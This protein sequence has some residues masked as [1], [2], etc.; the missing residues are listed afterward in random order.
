MDNRETVVGVF[1][2]GVGGLS[3]LRELER[4][5]PEARFV[6][7]ADTAHC[8]YG[9]KSAEYV[10]GRSREITEIL[11]EHGA[12]VIVIACNTATSAAIAVLRREY[13]TS[14]SPRV[15]EITGGR[16]DHV[17][18]I[19][20]EPAVK[21]AA[22]ATMT[23]VVGVLATAGTLHGSKY[24]DMKDRWSDG[25][26]IVESVGRGF[27]ELVEGSGLADRYKKGCLFLSSAE[28]HSGN[29]STGD[30][31]TGGGLLPDESAAGASVG[32]PVAAAWDEMLAEDTV[33]ASLAP[34]VEAGADTIV[35]GCTHYPF[36]LPVLEKVSD[37]LLVWHPM[38]GRDGSAVER[39]RFIDPAPAVAHRLIEVLEEEGMHK[40]LSLRSR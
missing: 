16:L 5:V 7:Y 17:P 34:L 21:P 35:L 38:T 36:L 1:D 40:D 4:A 14:P 2:S 29:A 9:E 31:L 26:E 33:R 10:L 3:V 30:A 18:F 6:Y 37:G 27:V 8:P 28:E 13:G 24:L 22:L 12:D 25:I 11:L 32:H 19:G 15:L 39:I 23:G 20:M